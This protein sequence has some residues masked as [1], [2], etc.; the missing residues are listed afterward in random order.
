MERDGQAAKGSGV[1]TCE[2]TKPEAEAPSSPSYIH[3]V[4]VRKAAVSRDNGL[5]VYGVGK[6]V[7]ARDS[8][9]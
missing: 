8:V 9:E 3:A 5:W 4:T 2:K 7:C 1:L 6:K